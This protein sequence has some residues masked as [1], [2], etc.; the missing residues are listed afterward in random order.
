MLQFKWLQYSKEQNGAYCRI[1]VFFSHDTVGKGA[2]QTLGNV[3]TSKFDN[4]KKAIGAKG[5]FQMHANTNYHKT[6]QYKYDNFLAV[7]N[8]KVDSVELQIN[9]ALKKEI[10]KK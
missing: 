10:K 4:W 8:N 6:C 2:H 3:V 5:H 1:C 9:K 7:K